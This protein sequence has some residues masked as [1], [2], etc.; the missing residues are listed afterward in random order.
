MWYNNYIFSLK[1]VNVP[2]TTMQ[3]LIPNTGLNMIFNE[4][5]IFFCSFFSCPLYSFRGHGVGLGIDSHFKNLFNI[6]YHDSTRS[7]PISIGF[8]LMRERA[9]LAGTCRVCL[10]FICCGPMDSLDMRPC[11]SHG[12]CFALHTTRDTTG[13]VRVYWW[14][15][16]QMFLGVFFIALWA[17]K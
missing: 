7:N 12:H 9:E 17:F 6:D 11:P 14:E 8:V 1:K 3:F 16:Y 13:G 10:S 4:R 2:N 15:M 5:Y